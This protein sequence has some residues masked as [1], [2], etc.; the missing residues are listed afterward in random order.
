MILPEYCVD[1]ADGKARP[2][3]LIKLSQSTPPEDLKTILEKTAGVDV[4]NVNEQSMLEVFGEPMVEADT[5]F[6]EVLSLVDQYN[7]KKQSSNHAEL[8]ETRFIYTDPTIEEKE[9]QL[10]SRIVIKFDDE[11]TA[12]DQDD[13]RFIFLEPGYAFGTGHHPQY[14]IGCLCT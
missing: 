5:F 10:T 11:E 3:A 8:V 12:A 6:K 9:L 13:S 14:E 7:E 4:L 2:F 1:L